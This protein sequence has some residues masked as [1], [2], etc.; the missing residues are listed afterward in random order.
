[1]TLGDVLGVA[2]P[3]AFLAAAALSWLSHRQLMAGA[4]VLFAATWWLGALGDVALF[5]HRGPLA[6]VLLAYPTG[7][8][9]RRWL[10]VVVAGAFVLGCIAPLGRLDGVTVGYAI[11]VLVAAV[12]L[13]WR[14]SSPNQGI[15]R[16]YA[17][18]AAALVMGVL[19][20]GVL[21]RNTHPAA[22]Q[23]VLAAYEL[24]LL[25]VAVGWAG[26]D[27]WRLWAAPATTQLVVELGSDIGGRG[28]GAVLARALGDPS[29]AVLLAERDGV[30]LA[31]AQGRV[32]GPGT[33]ATLE[34][35]T[36]LDGQ[37]Q[38]IGQLVHDPMVSNDPR[39]LDSARDLAGLA[40][41][42]VRLEAEVND[43]VAQVEASRRRLVVA[44]DA[45][46]QALSLEVQAGP[47]T[48]L[49]RVDALL[50]T[51]A[52]GSPN[53]RDAVARAAVSLVDFAGGLDP[54]AV[55]SA[56]LTAALNDLASACSLP[57]E[58]RMTGGRAAPAAEL[59]AYFVVAEGVANAVKHADAT[60][61]DVQCQVTTDLLRV[62]VT[63]NGRGGAQLE[64]G[65]GLRGLVD[66]VETLGGTLSLTSSNG[67]GT[68]LQ[69]L[70][71]AQ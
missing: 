64:A 28:I 54:A 9:D 33:G 31:D 16:W 29:I 20:C 34:A 60:H 47:V 30:I 44:E 13:A 57:V 65:T 26:L 27:S 67:S 59:A 21:F 42:N 58:V 43:R 35:L 37:G 2:V 63:D 40:L 56:G 71:P 66:R 7:R 55:V 70:I 8:L 10:W 41:L 6:L 22:Q 3:M 5:W 15:P 18:V 50:S 51:D 32:A 38:P 39:V 23:S 25:A 14:A 24:S 45:E 53:L 36:V 1:M 49:R 62:S 4:L 46:R 48:R 69:A 68:S 19:A 17:V 12:V 52:A 11:S 61:V